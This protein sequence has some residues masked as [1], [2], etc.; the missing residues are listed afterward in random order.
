MRIL[1]GKILLSKPNM[2]L[3]DEP[4]NHLDIESIRWLEEFL[5]SYKGE[6]II[7]SHDRRFLDK[8]TNRT[9]EISNGK[10][11]DMNLPYSKFILERKQQ[12]EQQQAAYNNQQR[13][14]AD[15]ERFIERF[16]YKATLG[17]RVQSRIKQLEKIELIE[18]EEEDF[19]TIHFKFPVAPRS[20]RTVAEVRNL[21]KFYG[22]HLVLQN[23]NYAIERGDKHAFVGRNGE[24]KTT[25]TKILAGNEIFD[26]IY[27]TGTNVHIG[28]YA[29]HQAEMLDGNSTVFEVIDNIATGDMR[30]RVR[31]LLG[32]F[33]FSGDSIYKKV[34]VLSGGE[35]SRLAIARL[36]LQPINFLILDEPTNHLDM[37][38]KDV[39]KEALINFSGALILV[40][41]DREFLQGL[42]NK[43]Y[44]FRNA[45]IKE[46]IGTIDEYLDKRKIE[47]LSDIEVRN[48]STIYITSKKTE[49]INKANREKQKQIQREKSRLQRLIKL[50][51]DEIE[52]IE[53]QITQLESFFS[54]PE[55]YNSPDSAKEKQSEYQLLQQNLLT[56]ISEWENLH[57]EIANYQTEK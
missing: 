36:L 45:T 27:K 29:Q 47:E 35:K 13:L 15:A 14:I 22:S 41:H 37:L 9:I 21:T 18:P 40:S 6:I 5:S 7:V 48:N 50:C 8:I 12:R 4:T 11:F 38:A 10:I 17:S 26:G 33:L 19:S 43:T 55:F 53:N 23:I 30:T 25:L 39:L 57:N 34:K 31:S 51:E 1:L 24:G 56:R 46:Y 32:A 49:S 3:L 20:G 54:S 42:T 28:Y 52:N 16:R 2:I 44:E